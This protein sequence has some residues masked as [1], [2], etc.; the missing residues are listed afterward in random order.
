VS[1][2]PVL[3]AKS[4]LLADLLGIDPR[5]SGSIPFSVGDVTAGSETELQAA[6]AGSATTVDLPLSIKSSNYFQNV[7]YR[8]TVGDTSRRS[9]SRLENYLNQNESGVWENSWVRFPKVC[10]GPYASLVFNQDLRADKADPCS[11]YRSDVSRFRLVQH[12]CELVR[13]P[14]SY[15]VKLALAHVL[16]HP[17]TVPS[18]IHCAGLRAM[19]HFLNDNT[20]PET[21]SLHVVSIRPSAGNGLA[22]AS[23][24]AK[25]FLLT[26][27]LIAYANDRFQLEARGQKAVIFFSP[28]PPV[29]QKQLNDCISDAYYRELFMSPCLSGWDR[30]EE[31]RD[32]MALC[33]QVLSRSHLNAVGKLR[34]AGIIT[35]NLVTLP[36]TSNISLA[37]N[38][39]HISLGSRRLRELLSDPR[40]GFTR[41]SEKCFGD[42]AIKIVE[43]FLPLFVGA[44][45]A[46]P[47]RL[48]FADFHPEQLLGFLPHELDFT[49]LRMFWRRWR[50]KGRNRICGHSITPFGPAWID[51]LLSSIFR[52]RGDFIPDFRLIDYLVALRSTESSPGLDGSLDNCERLKKDLDD[53]GVF[54]RRM[55]MYLMYRLREFHRMGFSGFEGRHYS[56]FPSLQSDMSMAVELQQLVTC[57]AFKYMLIGKYGHEH[58]PDMPFI[59]SE[60]RQIFFGTA[61]G[62]PTFFVRKDT[63]NSLLRDILAETHSVRASR[64]YTGYVRVQNSEYRLALV[65][66]LR[67]DAGDLIEAL[68]FE[69]TLRDL[70]ARLHPSSG[71]AA[72]DRLTQGIL[73]QAGET[74]PFRCSADQFNRAAEE[75]YRTTLRKQHLVEALDLLETEV[76]Q[77]QTSSS[78]LDDDVREALYYVS[79]GRSVQD[80]LKELRIHIIQESATLDELRYAIYLLLISEHVDAS[81]ES[82]CG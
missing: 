5:R 18:V 20:S 70:E 28:H 57:L 21:Y 13:V 34:E 33:H 15:V 8:A 51:A 40:S 48:D 53:L 71:A 30:G 56:L 11:A 49:H 72:V 82:A 44:Y 69:D 43:H 38:G 25:R 58:I 4:G 23:E 1:S 31:K 36:N 39:A 46:A 74:S 26:H 12:G 76:G 68:G 24:T 19:N 60:R 79:R 45:S 37:N 80:R 65:R 67:R 81:R 7:V 47:Y 66:I 41:E 42:L 75:Y 10:L 78:V 73:Q 62:I 61:A 9:I 6:V 35:R 27:L 63:G 32:Y 59:E 77:L 2:K 55:S 52:L 50:R 17:Q 16:D 22:L 54:D 14:I 64:R 29:R 3:S